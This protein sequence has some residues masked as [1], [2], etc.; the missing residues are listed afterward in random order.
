MTNL[1]EV[2]P[3]DEARIY[4]HQPF[5]ARLLV[6]VAGS[7][8]HF[9]MAFVL[10]WVAAGVR[11]GAQRGPGPDPGP[12]SRGRP[13]QSRPR[14]G[15]RAGD[16]VVSVDGSP[17]ATSRAHPGHPRPSRA[18][19]VTVVVDRDGT[20]RTLTVT[21]V[22]GRSVHEAGRGPRRAPR[23][24]VSSGSAWAS[25]VETRSARCAR[26]PDRFRAGP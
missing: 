17:S 13:A 3:A 19:P 2:D 1:E 26:W 8:M 20:Q 6:A 11:R 21:P 10:L 25:P 9:L 24:S 16:V 15:L 14:G 5:H 23:P 4:R 22:D 7:A 12:R 18:V